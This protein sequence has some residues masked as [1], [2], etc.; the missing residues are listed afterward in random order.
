MIISMKKT[1][2]ISNKS[3]IPLGPGGPEGPV[4]PLIPLGP[5]SPSKNKKNTMLFL[6][7]LIYSIRL[8]TLSLNSLIT[9]KINTGYHFFRCGMREYQLTI[10]PIS[11]FGPWSPIGPVI[12]CSPTGPCK[13]VEPFIP[14]GP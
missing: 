11:P 1:E 10:G 9:L 4:F 3:Y 5:I 8:L 7:K 13:P 14:C 12:P 6:F 2:Y